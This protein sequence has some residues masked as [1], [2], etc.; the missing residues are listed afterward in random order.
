MTTAT[1]GFTGLRYSRVWEDPEVAIAALEPGPD[2]DL[3]VVA[4]C[5]AFVRDFVDGAVVLALH[6][7]TEEDTEGE[8]HER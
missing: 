1:D 6:A 5:A 8:T 7:P 2:D 4:L 3:L